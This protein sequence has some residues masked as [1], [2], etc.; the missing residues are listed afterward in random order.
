MTDR[1][2]PYERNH[3]EY[4]AAVRASAREGQANLRANKRAAEAMDAC[5]GDKMKAFAMLLGEGR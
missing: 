2:T 1:Y 4:V 5:G 3:P